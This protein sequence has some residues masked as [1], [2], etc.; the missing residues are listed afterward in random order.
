MLS[1]KSKFS[2]AKRGFNSLLPLPG[3]L[4]VV[5]ILLLKYVIE[6]RQ[7]D[8]ILDKSAAASP[9][10]AWPMRLDS[11]KLGKLFN[12]AGAGCSA[13]NILYLGVSLSEV[14]HQPTNQHCPFGS[15]R[16]PKFEKRCDAQVD[17]LSVAIP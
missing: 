3:L 2:P 17:P 14:V 13:H 16:C 8:V 10:R 6:I 15:Y 11:K 1:T 12:N 4:D 9:S 5:T 7:N